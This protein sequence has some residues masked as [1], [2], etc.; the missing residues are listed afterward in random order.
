[1]GR[2]AK[3]KSEKETCETVKIISKRPGEIICVDGTRIEFM[4]P[5]EVCQDCYDWLVA[6]FGDFILK[7]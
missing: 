1:M 7:V 5:V 2:P 6:S 4:K 3:D